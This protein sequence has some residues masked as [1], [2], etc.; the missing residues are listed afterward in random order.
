MTLDIS[1]NSYWT[2]AAGVVAGRLLPAPFD[3]E[4]VIELASV[5][6]LMGLTDV[7]LCRGFRCSAS[8]GP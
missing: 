2:I 4:R 5:G 1:S 8:Q 6:V 3:I 7:E